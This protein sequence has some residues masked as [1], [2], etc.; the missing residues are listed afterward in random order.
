MADARLLERPGGRPEGPAAPEAPRDRPRAAEA[1]PRPGGRRQGPRRLAGVGRGRG[2]RLRRRPRRPGGDRRGG[3]VPEDARRRARPGER[4]PHHQRRGR[5]APTARTGRRCSCACT[6]AGASGAASSATSSTSRRGRRRG[7]R[8]PPCMVQGEYAYGYLAAEAG[9]HRLVRICPFDSNARRQ[10][11]FASV[12]A[13]PEIDEDDRDRD[14]RQGPAHR[15]LPLERGRRPARQ[16]HRL[17]RAHHPP[18]H[19]HRGRLPERAQP[20]P[21]PRGGR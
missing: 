9:V 5:A 13:W 6:C 16:R 15:H 4:H 14:P 7:S 2:R 1:P 19:R 8:A 11:S 3:R 12:F 10:T 20:E 17:R 18:A 21:Q